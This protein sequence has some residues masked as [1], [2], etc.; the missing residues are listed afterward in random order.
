[1]M[2]IKDLSASKELDRKAMADVRGGSADQYITSNTSAVAQQSVQ[3][4][5][6]I[7]AAVQTPTANSLIQASNTE[8]KPVSFNDSFNSVDYGYSP[9]F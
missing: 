8:L 3:N 1:M 9:W 6:G 5:G 4:L 7:V 2:T